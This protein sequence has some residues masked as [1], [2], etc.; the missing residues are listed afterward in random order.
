MVCKLPVAPPLKKLA[1]TAAVPGI[2]CA[3]TDA[4]EVALSAVV[5]AVLG[6]PVVMVIVV[7]PVPGVLV[8]AS[9]GG[10]V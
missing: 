5:A 7:V 8:G 2:A 1:V 9:F 3:L 4:A 10:G 6:E